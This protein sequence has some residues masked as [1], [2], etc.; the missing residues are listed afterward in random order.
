M[1]GQLIAVWPETWDSIWGALISTEGVPS[2]I[3]CELYRELTQALKEKPSLEQLADI[4]DSQEQSRDAF[5]GI[6]SQDL[7]SERAIV[8][9]F[10]EAHN[11]IEDVAGREKAFL[12]SQ[13]L[14]AFIDKFSLRYELRDPCVLCPTLTGMFAELVRELRSAAEGDAHVSGL[15]RDFENS[16]LDVRGDD[17]D[18]RIKTAIQKQVNLL[19]ALGA[20]CN[21]VRSNQLGAICGELASWPHSALRNSL[22]NLYGFA[23]DYPGIRHAGNPA[24]ALRIIDMKDLIAVS[25]VLAGFTP[26]LRDDFDAGTVFWGGAGGN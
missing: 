6:S 4:V 25:I 15:L 11:V 3:F 9:F 26:Y 20:R 16:L 12:Y 13:L 21:G 8:S 5:K 2:D 18:G 1:R 17:S 19:E 7:E 23:S 14:K 24:G 22:S 10:E